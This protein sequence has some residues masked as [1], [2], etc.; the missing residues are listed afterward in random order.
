MYS[1]LFAI[2]ALAVFITALPT[3]KRLVGSRLLRNYNKYLEKISIESKKRLDEL[4]EKID[5]P[6]TGQCGLIGF[7]YMLIYKG[8]LVKGHD[9]RCG[10]KQIHITRALIEQTK[11]PQLSYDDWLISCLTFGY[12]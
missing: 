8:I 4:Y 9:C 3:I 10:H 11:V 1:L 5:H 12:L 7:P 6:E 2:A